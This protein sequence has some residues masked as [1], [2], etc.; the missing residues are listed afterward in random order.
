VS[1]TRGP[2]LRQ[3]PIAHPS[4]ILFS[5]ELQEPDDDHAPAGLKEFVGLIDL[6]GAG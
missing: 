4:E 3:L 2:G 1:V 5:R 6:E